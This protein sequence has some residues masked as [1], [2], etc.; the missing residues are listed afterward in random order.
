MAI[1]PNRRDGWAIV[2]PYGNI[3]HDGVFNTPH[4]AKHHI[5]S[6]WH[7]VREIDWSEWSVVRATATVAAKEEVVQLQAISL[8]TEDLSA[9]AQG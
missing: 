8:D 7:G 3:W 1:T 2:G 9:R 5:E 4:D 6:F